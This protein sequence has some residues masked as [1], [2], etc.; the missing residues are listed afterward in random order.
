MLTQNTTSLTDDSHQCAR[1]QYV[2]NEF[3]VRNQLIHTILIDNKR[4]SVRTKSEFRNTHRL[5][6]MMVQFL[7][8]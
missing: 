5:F 3:W 8:R 7:L 1:G 2:L 4:K 6:E